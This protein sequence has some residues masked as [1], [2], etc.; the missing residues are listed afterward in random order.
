MKVNENSVFGYYLLVVLLLFVLG[1][2]YGWLVPLMVGMADTPIMLGGFAIGAVVGPGAL[3][4]FFKVIKKH[5]FPSKEK[6]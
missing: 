1:G 3:V 5:I 2:T 4:L 6:E